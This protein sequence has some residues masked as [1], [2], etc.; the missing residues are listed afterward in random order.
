MEYPVC[1]VAAFKS[2]VYALLHASKHQAALIE[3]C[4]WAMCSSTFFSRGLCQFTTSALGG[5]QFSA[6]SWLLWYAFSCRCIYH[7][8]LCHCPYLLLSQFR[9]VQQCNIRSLDT[10]SFFFRESGSPAAL[11][12]LPF[13][14]WPLQCKVAPHIYKLSQFPSNPVTC[15]NR[16]RLPFLSQFPWP[17]SP[18]W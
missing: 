1:D 12:L 9:C 14:A 11:R 6:E 10:F 5:T 4:P 15:C 18:T 17:L 16:L 13:P 8:A 2:M 3:T 7:V